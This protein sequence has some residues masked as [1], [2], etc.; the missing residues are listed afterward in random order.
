MV[1][2]SKFTTTTLSLLHRAEREACRRDRPSVET[3]DL[4]LALTEGGPLCTSVERIFQTLGHSL[5][6]VRVLVEQVLAEGPRLRFSMRACGVTYSANS[7]ME[8]AVVESARLVNGNF[9]D[10]PHLLLGVLWQISGRR[11]AAKLA[12]IGITHGTVLGVYCREAGIAVPTDVPAP[13]PPDPAPAPP[14]DSA[15]SPGESDDVV[16]NFEADTAAVH[17]A[18]KAY[19]R[20]TKDFAA[21]IGLAIEDYLAYAD[22][23]EQ[24][25]RAVRQLVLFGREYD[26]LRNKE[27]LTEISETVDTFIT[28]VGGALSTILAREAYPDLW[29]EAA[30]P[31]ETAATD[32]PDHEEMSS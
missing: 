25:K 26:P 7:A 10:P 27:V 29:A 11:V 23:I 1:D 30:A 18:V 6:S 24:V 31:E 14:A 16:E 22:T 2:K 9:V 5:A 32:G 12:A 3:T 19:G 4:L 17:E 28:E 13:P 20:K 21:K 15:P 8:R